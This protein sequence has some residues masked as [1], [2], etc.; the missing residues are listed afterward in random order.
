MF[1]EKGALESTLILSIRLTSEQ[2]SIISSADARL[3]VLEACACKFPV[4]RLARG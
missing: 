4:P 2:V 1:D 3:H